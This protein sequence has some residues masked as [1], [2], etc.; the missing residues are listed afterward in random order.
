MN[1]LSTGSVHKNVL[2]AC[3]FY[4]NWNSES[5]AFFRGCKLILYLYFPHLVS[6]L[7]EIQYKRS[8]HNAVEHW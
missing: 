7:C 1:C 4:E 3:G 5:P 2:G 8:A 6:S